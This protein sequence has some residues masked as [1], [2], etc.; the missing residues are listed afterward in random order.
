M[1]DGEAWASVNNFS[2]NIHADELLR[3][4]QKK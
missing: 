4:I 1:G 3:I 2:R